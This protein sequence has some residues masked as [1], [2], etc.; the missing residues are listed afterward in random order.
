MNLGGMGEGEPYPLSSGV[1]GMM[2][3]EM[4][5]RETETCRERM[6]LISIAFSLNIWK[7]SHIWENWEYGQVWLD[8]LQQNC[9]NAAI[10]TMSNYKMK[11]VTNFYKRC[12]RETAKSQIIISDNSMTN[13]Q[14]ER[15]QKW[16]KW[17]R[18]RERDREGDSDRGKDSSSEIT[19]VC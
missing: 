13:R 4:I 9:M 6:M 12:L 5:K 18:Q 10:E 7:S 2:Y 1:R 3:R 16:Q 8:L 14:I 19:F 11:S 17:Q 15:V